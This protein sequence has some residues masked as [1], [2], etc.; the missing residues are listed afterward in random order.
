MRLQA[1]LQSSLVMC[2]SRSQRAKQSFGRLGSWADE[3]LPELSAMELVT[4]TEGQGALVCA[5]GTGAA[6]GV[7]GG[8]VGR[9]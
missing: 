5:A 9:E 7:P 4:V 1:A 3:A 2:V 8:G 6:A